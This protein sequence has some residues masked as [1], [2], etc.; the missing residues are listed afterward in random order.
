MTERAI[1]LFGLIGMSTPGFWL[2]P[3]LILLFA[4]NLDWL[5]VSERGG[6]EHV[7]LPAM[8][9]ALGLAAILTQVTR[10]S[11]IEVVREDFVTVEIRGV[12]D[13]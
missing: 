5:P 9:L 11:M 12:I 3:M 2:G 8:T 7:I 10:A 13:L 6:F 1:L 4:M